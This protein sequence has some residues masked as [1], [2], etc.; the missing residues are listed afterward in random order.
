MNRDSK[1]I[2]IIGGGA[3]ALFILNE[4]VQRGHPGDKLAV[5]EAG[6]RLGSGMPYSAD[7]ANKEHLTNLLCEEI[8]DLV[9][10]V[11]HWLREQPR[12]VLNP[13]NMDSA[14]IDE[15]A[16]LP[17]ILFGKYLE[18]QFI[19]LVKQA[20]VKGLRVFLY[21]EQMVTDLEDSRSPS[22]VTVLTSS[23]RK[24][25]YDHVVIATGHVWPRSWESSVQGYFDSPYPPKKIDNVFNRCVG[26]RGSSL[27]AVDAVKTLA[28]NHGHYFRD[29]N[30]VLVYRPDEGT[31]NFKIVLHSR[32]G[33]LPTVR[34][35]FEQQRVSSDFYL[36][37]EE[38]A[39]HMA[40]NRNRVS[41][42]FLFEK[43]F[44][45]PLAERD[46][47]FHDTIKDVSLEQFVS[48]VD[49]IRRNKQPFDYFA[50]ELRIARVSMEQKEAIHWKEMIAFL[51]ST[52]NLYAKHMFAEDILRVRRNLMPLI[53]NVI[54]HLPHDSCEELLALHQAGKLDIVP[55]GHQ[56]HLTTDPSRTGATYF[57]HNESGEPT[58]ASFEVFID[59]IGQKPMSF[60]DFPFKT[61]VRQG[62]V[63]P[64]QIRFASDEAARDKISLTA[65]IG[66]SPDKG[67]YMTLPGIAIDDSFRVV[68]RSG[69]SNP[70]IFIVA[71]PLINGMNPDYP[72]LDFCEESAKIIMG[73]ITDAHN[74]PVRPR[75]FLSAE[76]PYRVVPS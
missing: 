49:Q 4:F 20:R 51:N 7:G 6:R 46:R 12:D 55:V 14:H 72:G 34:F 48:S 27:T 57:Y 9:Q 38:I 64:A 50:D 23:G 1:Y 33:A 58:S 69:D 8:P 25:D 74:V 10:P 60:E 67:Y 29:D 62:V 71:A 30:N 47:A 40:S 61:L 17:R 43:G 5:Y 19:R 42:D 16:A 32:H 18:D 39:E 35:H 22:K 52:I 24:A 75:S 53:S 70:R 66:K 36:S 54:A 31:E 73:S 21:L 2:A 63:A 56:G 15:Q 11:A 37:R 13:F 44:K 68:G 41:L 26:V 45:K 28:N 59:C 3:S 65:D 76:C